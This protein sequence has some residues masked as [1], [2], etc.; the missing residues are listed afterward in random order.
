MQLGSPHIHDDI[1]RGHHADVL[2]AA[3]RDHLAANAA[4]S[5]HTHRLGLLFARNALASRL[6]RPSK[7]A[8]EPEAPRAEAEALQAENAHRP[9]EAAGVSGS[10]WIRT[11]VG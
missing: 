6:R 10:G 9:H 4:H 1:A 11:N 7:A 3:R 2:E 8:T 5:T